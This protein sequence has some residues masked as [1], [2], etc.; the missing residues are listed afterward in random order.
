MTPSSSI[1]SP[2]AAPAHDEHHDHHPNYLV[3]GT[4]I[5]S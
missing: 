3:D 1:A 5:K 2:G 4:T